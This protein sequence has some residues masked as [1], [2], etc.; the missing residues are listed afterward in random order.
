M[1]KT[2]GELDESGEGLISKQSGWQIARAERRVKRAARRAQDLTTYG[3]AVI[4]RLFGGK[5]VGIYEFGYVRVDG[6]LLRGPYRRLVEI[7][8]SSSIQKKSGMGR[9]AGALLTGGVN[10]LSSNTRG[11]VYLTIVTE[12]GT[13]VLQA[14]PPSKSSLATA[15]ELETHGKRVLPSLTQAAGGSESVAEGA[16]QGSRA[17]DVDPSLAERLREL[18][19]LRDSALINGE[20]YS[21]LRDRLLAEL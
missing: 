13:E 4:E 15:K 16:F 11:D 14:S 20:E 1:E 2:V 19:R 7:E 3:R 17:H 18:A 10:L 6:G 12:L 8:A 9:G 5:R 21:T